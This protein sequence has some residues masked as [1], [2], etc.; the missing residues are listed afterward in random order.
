MSSYV[1]LDDDAV[2]VVVGIDLFHF[3]H[4]PYEIK[5]LYLWHTKLITTLHV[6]IVAHYVSY[7]PSSRRGNSHSVST[8]SAAAA[9]LSLLHYLETIAKPPTNGGGGEPMVLAAWLTP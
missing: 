7:V 1:C 5:P 4:C 2:V 3:F 8:Q 9:P 6:I